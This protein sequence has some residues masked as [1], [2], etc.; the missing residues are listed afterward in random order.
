MDMNDSGNF[1]I[2]TCDETVSRDLKQ[3][4]LL[5][6]GRW[7]ELFVKVKHVGVFILNRKKHIHE[8]S[9]IIRFMLC[10]FR[11]QYARADEVDKLRQDYHDG[12]NTLKLFMDATDEKMTAPV[13]VS[14]LNIRAFVQDVEVKT[15][16]M[17]CVI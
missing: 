7:R 6:N 17:P 12:I 2:E 15:T 8:F 10:L 5:L 1:L 13:Q 16:F 14:F 9:L 11:W 4:L 3:Q